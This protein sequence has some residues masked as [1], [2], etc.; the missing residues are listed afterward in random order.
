ML[1]YT[2]ISGRIVYIIAILYKEEKVMFMK[3]IIALLTTVMLLAGTVCQNSVFASFSDVEDSNAYKN[4]ITTL[5][6]LSVIDG[7]DENGTQLFK[8]D[9]PITRAEFTKLIVFMLGHKDLTYN[10]NEFSDVSADHWA[11]N[12][13]QTGYNLGIISGF[14]DGIFKPDDSVSYEQA[15]KM[16][17][18]ALGYDQHAQQL[19]SWPEGY[20]K[21]ADA[22]DIT[23]KISGVTYKDNA[24]RGVIAQ[25]LYNALEIEM[26]EN[27]GFTWDKTDKTLLKDYLKV[28]KLKGT[29]TGVGDYVT[30]D[31]SGKPLEDEMVV[32]D[33]NGQEYSINYKLFTNSILDISKYL[34]HTITV[35][36]RQPTLKDD[37]VLVTIDSE[38][39][40]NTAYELQY[41]DI[42]S[43]S[44][45]TLKYY[46]TDTKTKSL[47][48]KEDDLTVR[49][50][51]TLVSAN[52]T[53]TLTNPSTKAEESFSR[54]E[55]LEQWLNPETDYSIYGTVSLT[56]NSSDGTIDMI[57]IYNYQTMVAHAAPTTSD[58]RITD[59]LVTGNFLILD[60]QGIGYTYTIKKNG[61]EIPVTSIA[62]NDVILYAE[63]L[64]KSMYTLLVSNKTV[65]GSISA[66]NTSRNQF[67]I[68]G[69]SYN[70]G[71]QC[72]AYIRDKDGKELKTGVTGT[73]YLDAFGT[74]VFGTLKQ[75]AVIPYGY[76]S[77]AFIEFDGGEKA[78]VTVATT[79]SA[80]SY[81]LKDRVKY[82]GSTI[83]SKI[84]IE[85]LK[86]SA[87]Y[88]NDDKDFAEEIYGAGKTP[89]ITDYSQPVRVTVS[90]GV[91][92]EII[93]LKSDETQA[94]NDD[95]EQIVRCKDL[96]KYTYSSNSFS[97]AGKT[98]FSVNS[99]TVV[100]CVPSDRNQK[101]KY[102]KKSVS[103]AFT[104]GDSYYVEAYDVS[105]S[106]IAGLV[107]LYGN[108]SVLTNVKKDTDYSIV[109]SL[110]ESIYN[111]ATDDSA[112]KFDVY[113]G[114]STTTKSWTTFDNAEF[115]DIQVGDIVQFAYDGDN[116]AQGRIDI[117]RF[118]DIANV[119]D[120]K[121]QYND[122]L[123]SWEEE[124]TPSEENNNQSFKFDY[125]FKKAGTSDDEV[126]TSSSLGTV[127]YSRAC[128]Y[129]VSQVLVDEKKIYVTRN[130]F[131][132]DESGI[133]QLDDSDYEEVSITSSTK[134][135]RMEDERDEISK[136]A[137]GT[138][139]A[140]TINDLKDAKNYGSECSKVLI[141]SSRGNAKMILIY[142]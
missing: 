42:R 2:V 129:N 140:L 47:K 20:I 17:V 97:S 25:A 56:D 68:N 92:T 55:A 66:L 23:N 125:R 126:Y 98:A 80:D 75:A 113:S 10:T 85:R 117:M 110:P 70:I 137:S 35:Y 71:N 82:N 100:L 22:L 86:E 91:V 32:M 81:P 41:D 84:A 74:A 36:Y 67:T 6:K 18:C 12:Y 51:G 122:E 43:F 73:F 103:G 44:G 48:F 59:K 87:A 94:Q 76:I 9:N 45:N 63:S 53:V 142:K 107:I 104:S 64:D 108:D 128:M 138:T 58:Y 136:N 54:Q 130:G 19:G 15:L 124:L 3:K 88:T 8:P 39:T 60:P 89:T 62:A 38:T 28:R 34:G 46:E 135:L 141:L 119:L 93:T 5:S 118:A 116:L 132:K 121:D 29:L 33:S 30:E 50:N 133:Y 105:S 90:G 40:K 1:T 77:N 7:Y 106:K 61:N 120:G 112:L 78:Y 37:R 115:S 26:Y 134:I 101:S 72:E 111:E 4:A 13:I 102:T 49:Y 96:N 95:K 69:E 83:N 65:N 131:T 14:G 139:T 11:K 127:P 21:Q 99:S 27:N 123:Y 31:C 24:T 109:A 52:D 16:I 79:S 57:Q 114:S